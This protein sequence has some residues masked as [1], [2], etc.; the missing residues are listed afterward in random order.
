MEI[1]RHIIIQAMEL[2]DVMVV[3]PIF[4]A[5]TSFMFGKVN[6]F[7]MLVISF[8]YFAYCSY[9]KLEIFLSKFMVGAL[10]KVATK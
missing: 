5:S 9:D 1:I 10:I 4:Y 8:G 2:W 3:L 6:V 7:N